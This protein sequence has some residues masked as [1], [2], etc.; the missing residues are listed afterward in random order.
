VALTRARDALFI[1]ADLDCCA[2]QKGIFKDLAEY[3]RKVQLLRDTSPAELELYSWM[4]MEGWKPGIH[5]RV[6]DH[7]VDFLLHA[8]D[9][10]RIAVE[11]DG[12][13]HHR[14]TTAQDRGIDA[15]IEASG[16][17]VVRVKA[18]EALDTPQTVIDKI[19]KAMK[20]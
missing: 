20:V 1:V 5:V 6:Q 4:V 11:V 16:C 19:R 13:E 15:A 17:M 3:C 8:E 12:A 10:R 18:K 7:E 2:Q 14:D 9:G